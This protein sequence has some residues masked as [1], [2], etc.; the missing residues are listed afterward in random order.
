M[1]ASQSSVIV[2]AGDIAARVHRAQGRLAVVHIQG[3]EAA[4]S[5]PQYPMNE[6]RSD[7]MKG[8]S[9]RAYAELSST[10]GVFA[11]RHVLAPVG[12]QPGIRSVKAGAGEDLKGTIVVKD[13]T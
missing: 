13:P 8:A 11:A 10:Y 6:T 7:G 12:R 4:V 5:V 2:D 3:R 1:L 9:T